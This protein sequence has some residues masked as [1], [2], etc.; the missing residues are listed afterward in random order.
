MSLLL[1]P[2]GSI[3]EWVFVIFDGN[4]KITKLEGQITPFGQSWAIEGLALL[5]TR[6]F[7]GIL[8][9]GPINEFF[10][11]LYETSL[12]KLQFFYVKMVKV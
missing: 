7:R 6:Y 11:V 2:Q 8:G 3:P 9:L 5:E 10:K 1:Q 12:S 4:S